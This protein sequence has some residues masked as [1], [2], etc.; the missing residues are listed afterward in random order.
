M[1]AADAVRRRLAGVRGSVMATRGRLAE[2]GECW[3]RAVWK[4]RKQGWSPHRVVGIGAA[5]AWRARGV[6]L[7]DAAEKGSPA[8]APAS[9]STVAGRSSVAASV[10]DADRVAAR[11]NGAANAVRAT[12]CAGPSA[13]GSASSRASSTV[14]AK[15]AP[16]LPSTEIS[17]KPSMPANK[18]AGN[19]ASALLDKSRRRRSVDPV[20][21][22][23]Q[24]KPL[25][26]PASAWRRTTATSSWPA[27]PS[28]G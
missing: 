28:L 2:Q 9:M 4:P 11:V 14:R 1:P 18:P 8:V 10:G 26:T 21:P 25:A 20:P 3:P 16:G 17:R 22:S 15:G 6:P 23:P 5:S 7:F 24:P 12:S 19:V 27:T 13:Q